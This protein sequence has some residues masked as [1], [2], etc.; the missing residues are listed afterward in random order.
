MSPAAQTYLGIPGYIIFWVLFAVV[1]ALF[2]QR[3]YKL[4]Q[5]VRLGGPDSR[6]DHPGRRLATMISY[7]FLQKCSLRRFSW[8]DRAG[9]GHFF[10]FWGFMFF[11]FSYLIYIFVGDGLGLAEAIRAT[12]FSTYYS[13][14]LDT[15]GLL[16]LTAIVWAA[17]RRYVFRPNRLEITAEAAIIL[18]L[19][20]V[21]MLSHL[22]I[23][24]FLV[25]MSAGH[26]VSW[27]P[28][29]Q[30]SADLFAGVDLG[31]QKG[32]FTGVW[33]LHYGLVLGFL[34]FIPY[35]KHLHIMSSPFNVA[36]RSFKPRG[37]LVPIDLERSETFGVD[38]FEKF[39]WKQLLDGLACTHCGRCQV[40]CPGWNSGKPLNPKEVTLELKDH[41]LEVGDAVL[42]SKKAAAPAPPEGP[43]AA[44]AKQE[45]AVKD[46]VSDV[47]TEEVIWECTT[48]RACQEECPVLIEHVQKF[49]DM[50]RHLVLERAQVPE[51]ALNALKSIESRGHPW[52]G[53]TL[54]RTDWTKGL[55]IKV[56]SEDRNIDILYWVGC[57][58]ALEDRNTRVAIALARVMQRAGVS[59]GILGGEE[60]CCG[61]T[62]RRLG[63]EYV[64]QMLAQK[65]IELL[66]GY[67][68]KKVVTAC[69]HCFN[70]LKNEYPQFGGDFEVVHH[71]ELLARLLAEGKISLGPSVTGKAVYHDSCYLGRYNEIYEQPRQLLNGMPGVEVVEMGRRRNRGF[72]CGGGGG[73][74]WLE[75]TIGQ[76]INRMR[77]QEALD[78]GAKTVA[79]ACPYCLQ[80]FEEG[81]RAKDIETVKALDIAELI[82]A[83]TAKRS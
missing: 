7:V 37:A 52:R 72:C 66:K 46:M 78:T 24:G 77:T 21:L 67:G 79:T 38:K 27:T 17:V 55:G 48:C 5:F 44:S 25:N 50:R 12:R 36:F 20:T 53:T 23:E 28:I 19:I 41:M 45:P 43:G 57:T 18:S 75:E 22:A 70:T 8:R 71:T 2:L 35:S 16:V 62:A 11:M 81:I 14:V 54:T 73:R 80:M 76:R 65:N 63:N 64:F 49:I 1:V 42:A 69:P 32:L 68:V 51:T 26:V 61:E 74:M 56:M 15:A 9:L 30:A 31:V 40:A 13:L 34:V 33:W 60:T 58:A 47:I 59:F 10:I 3:A 29:R 6:S 4:W 39:T 83:A 82:E